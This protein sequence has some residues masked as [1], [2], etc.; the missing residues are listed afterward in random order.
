MHLLW[1]RMFDKSISQQS[2][3]SSIKRVNMKNPCRPGIP[4]SQPSY[5]PKSPFHIVAKIW[6]ENRFGVISER[7]EKCTYC[8]TFFSHASIFHSGYQ[9]QFYICTTV[10]QTTKL[11]AKQ[12]NANAEVARVS[13]RVSS[14]SSI[15]YPMDDMKMSGGA[16]FTQPLIIII[17]ICTSIC[18][19]A[20]L[21]GKHEIIKAHLLFRIPHIISQWVSEKG[22]GLCCITVEKHFAVGW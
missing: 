17:L 15:Q 13:H 16:R 14:T 2:K 21:F 1:T 9:K 12:N 5:L 18:N 11:K 8:Q 19:E 4:T 3:L 10:F 22:G 7:H 6:S 20:W